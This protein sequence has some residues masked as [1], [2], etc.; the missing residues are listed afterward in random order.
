MPNFITVFTIS[1]LFIFTNLTKTVTLEFLG[2]TLRLVQTIGALNNSLNMMI[3]SHVHL[4]KFIELEN[5]KIIE[6]PGYYSIK[7][8]L[9]N[10]V[11]LKN[12][13]FKY[14]KAEEFIFENL[15]LEIK[16]NTHTIITGPNG[17]GKSTLLGI[18]SK[19]FYPEE[20]EVKINSNQI[21]YVGVTPLIIRGTLRQNFLYGNK[22]IKSDEEIQD[23]VNEF[24]L[25]NNDEKNLDTVVDSKSLSSGQM[26]KVS[27]IRSLLADVKLL[28]LDEST[29]NLDIETKDLIF[30][31]LKNK[32]ITIINSTHNKDDFDY[33]HH[34]T[35]R[36]SG[37]KRFVEYV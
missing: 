27:F 19:I 37:E 23:L 5:N 1:L 13:K 31:I 18:V 29:S 7:K 11:E 17:S 4:S 35:I 30:K 3:N 33:D 14:Y 28:L 25:F 20:G 36:Y 16:R 12:I 15:N 9:I 8:D 21:G 10:A 2:V 34:L 6:R 32:D 22:N 24:H 26:Q